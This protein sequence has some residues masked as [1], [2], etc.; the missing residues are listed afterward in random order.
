MMFTS[1][2]PYSYWG[3]LF[4]PSLISSIVFLLKPWNLELILTLFVIY[5]PMPISSL[6]FLPRFLVALYIFSTII[7]L[8]PNLNQRHFKCI[9]IGCS[10]SQ[11]GFKCYCP[12]SRKFF[13]SFNVTFYEDHPF[14]PP[15]SSLEELARCIMA[16]GSPH[17]ASFT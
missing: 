8:G 17:F 3:K 10:P 6:L 9:F 16:L 1:Y 13:V 7:P 14:Y 12:P 11:K 2:V 4:L 15:T 5:F